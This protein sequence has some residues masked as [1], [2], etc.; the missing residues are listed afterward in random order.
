M[1][2]EKIHFSTIKE[3][4]DEYFLEY[5]PPLHGFPFANL[6]LTYTEGFDL[7]QV[8]KAMEIEAKAWLERFPVPLMVSAFDDIGH[9]IHLDGIRPES[10]IICFYSSG[11]SVPECHWRLL[12]KE[13]IPADAINKDFLLRVYEGVERKTSSE[14]R[15]E[16]EKNAKQRR[17]GWYIIFTWAVVVPAVVLVLEF[18]SPQW[19]A[20]LV[21]VY[22]LSKAV[23]KA[24][25]MLGK[26]RKSAAEIAMEEEERRM[27]HH[28]YH[29][30]QN[31]EGFMRLKLE[32]FRRE[33]KEEIKREAESIRA[34]SKSDAS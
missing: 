15:F 19:V 34:S 6:Q 2:E 22:G 1:A 8:A 30:E 33:Q 3:G 11:T 25:K 7:E 21:L 9:L 23:I 17:I 28:H 26:W 5:R 18:L 12:K 20:V 13:E 29:C 27:K 24:L 4:R 32:N 16:A 14:L 10:H 31:P